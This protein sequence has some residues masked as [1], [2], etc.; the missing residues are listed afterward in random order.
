MVAPADIFGSIYKESNI[1]IK[2]ANEQIN[3]ISWG[4]RQ[5]RIFGKQLH[6]VSPERLIYD[7]VAATANKKSGYKP[8]DLLRLIHPKP[9][10][11]E[12]AA[13]FA[14]IVGGAALAPF[15]ELIEA[16]KTVRESESAYDTVPLIRKFQFTQE[17]VNKALLKNANVCMALH[18][19][20]SAFLQ[21]L[22]HMIEVKV[23]REWIIMQLAAPPQGHPFE[24]FRA[25]RALEEVEGDADILAACEMALYES[26]N[27]IAPSNR[28]IMVSLDICGSMCMTPCLGYPDI[29]GR[30]FVIFMVLLFRRVEPYVKFM[31]FSRGFSAI[32]FSEKDTIATINRKISILPF[33]IVDRDQPIIYAK[34]RGLEFDSSIIICRLDKSAPIEIKTAALCANKF[35]IIYV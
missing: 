25:Y 21:N 19:M 23:P 1:F 10:N 11:E 32:E 14:Y 33:S 6:T 31:V 35:S 13:A 3:V 17:H 7:A 2:I 8:R 29:T 26:F 4:R 24:Y 16:F 27:L 22:R 5:R 34:N 18:W 12:Y 28:R 15:T 9:E 20:P 30:D